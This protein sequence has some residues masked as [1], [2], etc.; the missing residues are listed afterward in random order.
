MDFATFLTELDGTGW[1]PENRI[2]V[3]RVSSTNRLARQVVSAY[4]REEMTPP[5]LLVL[6]LE[7]VAGRGRQGRA[8]SSPAGGGVYATLVLSVAEPEQLQTVPL[9][10]AVGLARAL[11][12]LLPNAGCA[13]KWPNDLM[14]G[15]RKLGGVLVESV[16][17]V[18]GGS[19]AM[20][21]FGVNYRPVDGT[22]VARATSLADQLASPPPLGAVAR[23]LVAGLEAELAHLGDASYAAEGFRALSI[24]RPGDAIRCRVADELVAGAFA[25]FDDH[26]FLRLETASGETLISAGEIVETDN[27][28]EEGVER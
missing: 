24:H 19:V 3:G 5:G 1:G 7:Q 6:A 22:A 14:A 13:L 11:G 28:L 15:G 21:G 12:T 9:L 17:R 18:G 20:I 27:R 25:G 23:T 2:V 10:A 4:Q 26:G 8:W 16:S